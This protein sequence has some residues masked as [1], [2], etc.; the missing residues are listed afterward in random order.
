VRSEIQNKICLALAAAAIAAADQLSKAY[1]RSHVLNNW[2]WPGIFEFTEHRNH[3]LI[4]NLPVP[5]YMIVFVMLTVMALIIHS[6]FFT[7][8][9]PTPDEDW[10]LVLVL[11]GAAGNLIDRLRLGYVQD[12]GM[13]FGTSIVNLADVSIAIGLVWYAST[14]RKRKAIKN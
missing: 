2:P 6:I 13:F 14:L 10:S 1:I 4:A 5:L 8:N 7:K 3:G 11:G 9:K 12:W